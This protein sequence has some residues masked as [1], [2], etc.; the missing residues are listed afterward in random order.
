MPDLFSTAPISGP[1]NLDAG[2][3]TH[4]SGSP[5]QGRPTASHVQ[6]HL[7]QPGGVHMPPPRGAQPTWDPRLLLNPRAASLPINPAAHRQAAASP[8]S[9]AA[10][11]G[12][13]A[14]QIFQFSSPG[15]ALDLAG[16][17]EQPPASANGVGA[18]IERINNVESRAVVPEPKRRKLE[19]SPQPVPSSSRGSSG[20]LGGYIK[21]QNTRDVDGSGAAETPQTVDLTERELL[22]T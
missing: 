20:M 10:S 12:P 21:D 22:S 11:A 19:P 9:A 3:H 4:T 6:P 18:M 5:Q 2:C 17:A 1:R 14:N 8:R 7:A 15:P 16:A 13:A